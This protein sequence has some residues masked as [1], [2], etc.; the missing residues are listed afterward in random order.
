VISERRARAPAGAAGGGTGAS[1]RNLVNG[2]EIPA[3]LTLDLAAGDVV[4]IE[5]PGGGGFGRRG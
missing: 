1:G 2:D 5:T 3:K 4:T